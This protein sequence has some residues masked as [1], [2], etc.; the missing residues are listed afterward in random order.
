MWFIQGGFARRGCPTCHS[1]SCDGTCDSCTATPMQSDRMIYSGPNLPCTG[2]QT[3]DSITVAIMK[4]DEAICEI[5][6]SLTTTTTT[7]IIQ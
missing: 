5:L 6:N 4:I 2:I 7:T 1:S 3:C